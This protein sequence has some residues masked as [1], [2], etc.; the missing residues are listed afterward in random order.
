MHTMPTNDPTSTDPG[1]GLFLRLGLACFGL[2]VVIAVLFAGPLAEVGRDPDGTL[3]PGRRAVHLFNVALFVA[4]VALLGAWASRRNRPAPSLATAPARPAGPA[5]SRGTSRALLYGLVPALLLIGGGLGV[6]A[7]LRRPAV[8]PSV[9]VP[10]STADIR[11][12]QLYPAASGSYVGQL[13]EV[14]AV[15]RR[16]VAVRLAGRAPCYRFDFH[17]DVQPADSWRGD[18]LVTRVWLPWPLLGIEMPAGAVAYDGTRFP[19]LGRSPLGRQLVLITVVASA[20]GS[21]EATQLQQAR[22]S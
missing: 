16:G 22:S 2:Y 19:W 4:G 5:A 1:A 7:W 8:D 14:E 10:A 18:E 15:S 20:D 17:G 3:D 13:V 12:L 11:A 9:Q 6:K 21:L